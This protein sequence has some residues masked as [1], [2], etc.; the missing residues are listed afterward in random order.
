MQEQWK[1]KR[2][3]VWFSSNFLIFEPC[4]KSEDNIIANKKSQCLLNSCENVRKKTYNVRIKS[5]MCKWS[6]DIKYVRIIRYREWSIDIKYVRIIRY[7]GLLILNLLD[8][9]SWSIDIKSVRIIRYRGLLILNL[10]ELSDIV[11][12]WY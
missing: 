8:Q 9:I 7:R 10:L 2:I 11:D 6:I 12:Y 5:K 4:K 1:G 3:W